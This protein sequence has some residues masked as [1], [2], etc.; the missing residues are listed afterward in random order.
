M[1]LRVN[2]FGR[3]ARV[4]AKVQVEEVLVALSRS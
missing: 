3:R 2:K 4:V 1:G